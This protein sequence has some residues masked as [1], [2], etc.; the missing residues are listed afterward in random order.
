[1]KVRAQR[2]HYM[3]TSNRDEEA[4]N[5]NNNCKTQSVFERS[6]NKTKSLSYKTTLDRNVQNQN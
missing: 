6:F 5:N 3:G 2:T 1:M 4:F